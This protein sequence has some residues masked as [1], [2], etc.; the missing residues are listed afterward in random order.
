VDLA[1][2]SERLHRA[3]AAH[4]H[5]GRPPVVTRSSADDVGQTLRRY[6]DDPYGDHDPLLRVA[7]TADGRQLV[8]AAHHG[9]VDGLGL[10]AVLGI[11]L[12]EQ[13]GSAS[14]GIGS[15]R[16][17]RGFAS[18][19]LRRIAEAL[20]RPPSR[21]AAES[22]ARGSGNSLGDV[23]AV[24]HLDP[25]KAGTGLVTLAASRAMRRWNADHGAPSRRVVV[26]VGASR[27]LA[28]V[29]GPDRDTAYFRIAVDAA[30]VA[31]EVDSRLARTDPEPDFPVTRDRSRFA[32]LATKAL[33]GRLGSSLMVSNLGRLTG[34]AG[35]FRLSFFPAAAGVRAVAVGVAS[36]G[37][38]TSVTV[39]MPRADFTAASAARL[40]QAIAEEIDRAGQ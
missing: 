32:A 16:G 8:V 11:V 17:A 19:S 26:A 14:R 31:G 6:L 37:S 10:L 15:R 22:R 28:A 36:T 20:V 5:L 23:V 38:A 27:R 35:L 12:G 24:T 40:S 2:I 4:P 13:L 39:R 33:R 7:A 1:E 34:A 3:V 18:S 21:F 30:T 29:P 25:T 9:A